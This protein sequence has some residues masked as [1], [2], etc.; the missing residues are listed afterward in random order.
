MVLVVAESLQDARISGFFD[1]ILAHISA[2][3]G[4]ERGGERVV[5]GGAGEDE[6][7]E[8]RAV[9]LDVAAVEVVADKGGDGLGGCGSAG[10][11]ETTETGDKAATY[12]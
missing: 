4:E 7:E 9:L 5:A 1:S 3:P 2:R 12:F 10:R 11:G 8:Q 6:A